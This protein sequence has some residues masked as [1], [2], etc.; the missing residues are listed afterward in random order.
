MPDAPLVTIAI[1]TYNRAATY[2]PGVIEAALDQTWSNIEVLVGDNASTDDTPAVVARYSD[3][4]LVHVR[5][6]V[7]LGA[8]GNFNRLLE[9]A[10]GEWFLLLHDDDLLDPDFV[11]KCMA[12]LAGRS[13]TGVIRTGHDR[14]D[15][16]TQGRVGRSS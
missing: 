2:L 7:N 11:S 15:R 16:R 14:Y 6:P 4:R 1:P 10:R 5:H 8:N 3:P 9:L 12:A 13:Q